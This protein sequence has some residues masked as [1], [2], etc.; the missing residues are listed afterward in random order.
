[1]LTDIRDL[2]P[3][4]PLEA[5]VCIVGSGPAG[6]PIAT[7][8]EAAGISTLLVE[9]GGV[10]ADDLSESLAAGETTGEP[11]CPLTITRAK[12]FGGTANY[13]DTRW[14]PA[15][16]GFRGAPLDPIDFERKEWLPESGWPFGLDALSGYYRRAHEFSG[17]GPFEYDPAPWSDG[18]GARPL[19]F[20]DESVETRIWHFGAQRTFLEDRRD[21]LARSRHVRVLLHAPVIGLEADP[22]GVKVTGVRIRV[23]EGREHVVRAR[24]VVL[25]AGGL[26]NA[27]LLLLSDGVRRGG[28]G[29]RHDLVGRYFMEHQLVRGGTLVPFDRSLFD[30][31]SLYDERHVRGTPVMGKLR[32]SEAVMRREGL[33]NLAVALFPRHRWSHRFRW[34]SLDA[35]RE[36]V[37]AARSRTLPEGV[38][39]RAILAARGIDFITARLTRKLS[40]DR[41]F[42]Y[43]QDGPSLLTAGWSSLPDKPSRFARIEL[44]AHTEQA[45]HA[46]NRVTLARSLD[47][48]GCRQVSLHWEWREQDVDSVRRSL[49]LLGR[50]LESAGIGRLRPAEECDGRPPLIHAGLHHH[51]GTTR[52]HPDPRRGVVDADCRVHDAPNL[53]IAGSSVFPTGGYINPT[54]TIIAL[55]IRIADAVRAELGRAGAMVRPAVV[56]RAGERAG[57]GVGT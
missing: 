15:T 10:E 38:A 42:R 37:H 32:L 14:D 8:L 23:A 1:M 26:E 6:L 45:P 33:L 48:L 47:A 17:M 52:M 49:A 31:L 28:V 20:P 18:N 44:V 46:E 21:A 55:S 39:T 5:D 57:D 43:W 25:A 12:R 9:S 54:L 35:F 19:V 2:L 11:F 51:I 36:L 13:W 41:L 56:E 53:F 4:S 27:R 40:G 16:L 50:G 7:E 24:V 3:G 22:A 29:N 30:R 34:E